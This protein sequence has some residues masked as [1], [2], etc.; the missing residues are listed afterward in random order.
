MTFAA[1]ILLFNFF[2]HKFHLP[3]D[4]DLRLFDLGGV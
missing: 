3:C 2:V 1:Y 4:L